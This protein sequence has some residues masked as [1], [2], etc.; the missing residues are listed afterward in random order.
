MPDGFLTMQSADP[1]VL[2]LEAEQ[3]GCPHAQA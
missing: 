3:H 2:P 1:D